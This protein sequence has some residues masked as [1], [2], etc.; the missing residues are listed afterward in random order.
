LT[1]TI[2]VIRARRGK[3]LAT[4]AARIMAEVLA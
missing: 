1:G 3:R 2:T 4:I